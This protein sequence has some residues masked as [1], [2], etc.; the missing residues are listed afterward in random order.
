MKRKANVQLIN[1]ILPLLCALLATG[2]RAANA[3]DADNENESNNH[4]TSIISI[5][6]NGRIE[7]LPL[8][9]AFQTHI[10]FNKAEDVHMA[11]VAYP[12]DASVRCALWSSSRFAAQT[13]YGGYRDV[14]DHHHRPDEFP[15]FAAADRLYCWRDAEVDGAVMVQDVDGN[16]ELVRLARQ[17]GS[18]VYEARWQRPLRV[19]RATPFATMLHACRFRSRA[20]GLSKVF[21]KSEQPFLR[22]A[23]PG[24]IELHCH[25]E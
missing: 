6:I 24:A 18:F 22:E 21:S 5:H 12:E 9:P 11:Y 4:A 3:D 13:V 14:Y 2:A 15:R 19:R 23:F 20:G 25:D 1:L 8:L 10:N 17:P 16:E 7:E